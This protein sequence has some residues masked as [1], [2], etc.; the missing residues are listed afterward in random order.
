M[1]PSS[2]VDGVKVLFCP[3]RQPRAGVDLSQGGWERVC[4]G[5]V[6]LAF[7][8]TPEIEHQRK[9]CRNGKEEQW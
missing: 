2:D 5:S 3:C 9:E 8:R 1:A 4:D 7:E 6:R